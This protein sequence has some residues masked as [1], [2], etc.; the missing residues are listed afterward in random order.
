MT[1]AQLK[2]I[3]ATTGYPVAYR[4]FS[5]A[6]QPTLPFIVYLETS[7]DNFKA[8]NKVYKKF[9]NIT[10]ELYTKLKSET[11]ETNLETI[12]D[13]NSIPYEKVESYM[14]D[15][16]VYQIAYDIQIDK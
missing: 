1:L 8:D 2:T 13:N 6:T 3:L 14:E 9:S 7:S 11:A 10:I 16:Q 4:V 15:E 12:L 5:K